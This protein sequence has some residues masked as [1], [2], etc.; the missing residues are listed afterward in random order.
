MEHP[1]RSGQRRCPA[2][3]GSGGG[4]GPRVP[5]KL[6]A[7]PLDL[8]GG[9]RGSG[10]SEGRGGGGAGCGSSEGW[11]CES[12]FLLFLCERSRLRRSRADFLVHDESESRGTRR[13][14]FFGP[15]VR[16]CCVLTSMP[17]A[18]FAAKQAIMPVQNMLA[19]KKCLAWRAEVMGEARRRRK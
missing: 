1:R 8:R 7:V 2:A 17:A 5:L 15:G 19:Q 12:A 9:G 4:L 13:R 14:D 3:K 16:M 6:R 18:I 10:C 11:V